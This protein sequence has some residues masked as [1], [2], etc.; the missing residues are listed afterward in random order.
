MKWLL[1]TLKTETLT[2]SGVSSTLTPLRSTGPGYFD[3]E[4]KTP[5]PLFLGAITTM[6]R[7]P[8]SVLD[9]FTS[10]T[11]ALDAGVAELVQALA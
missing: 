5:V 3:I 10:G 11:R 1:S 4:L 6:N 2:S 9:R 7:L 8:R